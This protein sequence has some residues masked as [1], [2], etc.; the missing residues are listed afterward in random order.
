MAARLKAAVRK[1]LVTGVYF[2][3]LTLEQ[4]EIALDTIN[5]VRLKASPKPCGWNDQ[6]NKILNQLLWM[7][8]RDIRRMSSS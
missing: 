6:S 5:R 1:S 2:G 7:Y 8:T 3:N 4:T